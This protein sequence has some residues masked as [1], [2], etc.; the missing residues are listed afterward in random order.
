MIELGG[1]GGICR[2]RRIFF[3]EEDV[4]TLIGFVGNALLKHLSD[5]GLHKCLFEDNYGDKLLCESVFGHYS[6]LLITVLPLPKELK[7]EPEE[8]SNQSVCRSLRDVRVFNIRFIAL[9]FDDLLPK[10]A[11]SIHRI[12]LHQ[13]L[14]DRF[15]RSLSMIKD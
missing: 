12:V 11:E 4:A 9:L 2:G 14:C 15:C 8:V 3:E 10:L 13:D 1:L 5:D 7:I 6:L